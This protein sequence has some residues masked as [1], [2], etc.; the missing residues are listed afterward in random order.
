MSINKFIAFV[1]LTILSQCNAATITMNS[2]ADCS[3]SIITIKGAILKLDAK[4]LENV[5][6]KIDSKFSGI[7]AKQFAINFVFITSDGGNIDEAI[8]MGNVIRKHESWVFVVDHCYSSCVFI[9][10]AGVHR[11]S[12]GAIGIHRPYFDDL[13]SN[14]TVEQIRENRDALKLKMQNYFESMDINPN[15][16]EEMIS[17]PPNEMK[18]LTNDELRHFRLSADDANHEER[19]IAKQ[20]KMYGLT[21]SE[22]RIR[23]AEADKNCTVISNWNSCRNSILFNISISDSKKRYEVMRAV[24]INLNS[25]AFIECF[26]RVMATGK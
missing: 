3:N 6:Q 19:E 11:D 25:N 20:S 7:C 4:K 13:S 26:K 1:L 14:L 2:E 23:D 12:R 15:L 10:A 18:I 24:C 21:S 9:L 17:V 22:Y 8:N 16:V 5:F